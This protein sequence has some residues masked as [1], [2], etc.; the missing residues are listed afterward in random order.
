ML[1]KAVDISLHFGE[2]LLTTDSH[3]ST[4][5]RITFDKLHI[6]Q[7]SLKKMYVNK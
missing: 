5:V 2:L 7:L 4:L 3:H 6:R 1:V